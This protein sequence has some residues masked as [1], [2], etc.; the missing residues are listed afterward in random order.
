[1]PYGFCYMNDNAKVKYKLLRINNLL[2]VSPLL[3]LKVKVTANCY[4]LTMQQ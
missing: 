2:T 3:H 1:M 4:V